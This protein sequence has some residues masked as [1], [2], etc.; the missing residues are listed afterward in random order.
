VP[1][2]GLYNSEETRTPFWRGSPPAAKTATK[3]C[4]TM[5]T[6][7]KRF[8]EAGSAI[9][10]YLRHLA[11]APSGIH[12]EPCSGRRWRSR[13]PGKCCTTQRRPDTLSYSAGSFLQQ[14]RLQ[15]K[16]VT[17]WSQRQ[18]YI[19]RSRLGNHSVPAP[20]GS[21][22][23]W[24][25]IR[26][27]FRLPVEVQVPREELYNSEEARMGPAPSTWA[28]PPAAK[29]ATKP[30]QTMATTPKRDLQKQARQS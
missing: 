25:T 20:S 15:Q 7:P 11:V 22:T 1:R 23:I 26:A 21:S 4:H 6:T 19:C 27:V 29:T 13:C 3:T 2:E 17:R 18:K 14:P 9:R 30:C 5:V 16:P 12:I 24:K 10:T 28:A 8:A